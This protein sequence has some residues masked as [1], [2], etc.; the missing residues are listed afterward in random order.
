M[1]GKHRYGPWVKGR[2]CHHFSDHKPVSKGWLVVVLQHLYNEL[3]G[4]SWP[5]CYARP[6]SSTSASPPANSDPIAS[7]LP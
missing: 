7:S 6:C 2:G 1:L 4:C 3:T 5:H